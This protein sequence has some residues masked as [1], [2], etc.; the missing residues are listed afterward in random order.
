M[1]S[2]A[3]LGH[4][5]REEELMPFTCAL[6]CSI[7]LL[8]APAAQLLSAHGTGT[9]MAIRWHRTACLSPLARSAVLAVGLGLSV[10]VAG[11]LPGDR[12]ARVQSGF[13]RPG[14]H[15]IEIS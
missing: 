4:K 9:G 1:P 8:S 3:L 15:W 2:V 11:W 12:L 7:G 13:G 14:G 5:F 10:P 6:E